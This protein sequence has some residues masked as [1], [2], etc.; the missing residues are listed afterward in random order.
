MASTNNA[1]SSSNC[2]SHKDRFLRSSQLLIGHP[3]SRETSG[4]LPVDEI[5]GP[6]DGAAPMEDMVRLRKLLKV[7]ER[8]L[9]K[10]DEGLPDINVEALREFLFEDRRRLSP[11][12][13]TPGLAKFLEMDFVLSL[14]KAIL[15]D[16]DAEGLTLLHRAVQYERGQSDVVQLLLLYGANP[17]LG[18][19]D[20]KP[21][22]VRTKSD[23]IPSYKWETT[24]QLLNHR[25]SSSHDFLSLR[26]MFHAHLLLAV[27]S[28]IMIKTLEFRQ[29][30]VSER[31]LK[32]HTL[33]A[34]SSQWVSLNYSG[35]SGLFESV[36]SLQ[37]HFPDNNVR[38]TYWCCEL[39]NAT[40]STHTG[41]YLR[42]PCSKG[43][44]LEAS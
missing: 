30:V 16:R 32:V 27:E 40:G 20:T 6:S 36:D 31:Q 42:L 23:E 4:L 44:T 22:I 17:E 34:D 18:P 5:S 28:D 15:N 39:A 12:A 9:F 19:D 33:L 41:K 25:S 8:K 38:I 10:L 21:R 29:G 13:Y 14:T 37:I 7:D 24:W 35:H 26:T 1:E 11:R 3:A 2:E 43:W